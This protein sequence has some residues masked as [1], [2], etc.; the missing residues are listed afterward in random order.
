MLYMVDDSSP[1]VKTFTTR[2]LCIKS[3]S[4]KLPKIPYKKK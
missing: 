2:E 3:F 1:D 4:E